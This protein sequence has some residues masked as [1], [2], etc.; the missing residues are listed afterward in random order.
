MRSISSIVT[1]IAGDTPA[2]WI[3]FIISPRDAAYS[4]SAFTLSRMDYIPVV[5]ALSNPTAMD[6][7]NYVHIYIEKKL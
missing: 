2:A 7:T 4:A 5:N 6:I 3:T 1:F